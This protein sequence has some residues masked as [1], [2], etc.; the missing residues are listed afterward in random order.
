MSR[1][2][3]FKRGAPDTVPPLKDGPV[4]IQ[5]ITPPSSIEIIKQ[6]RLF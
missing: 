3:P 1:G 6:P 4:T 2:N 5:S